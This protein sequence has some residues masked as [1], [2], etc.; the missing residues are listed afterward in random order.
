MNLPEPLTSLTQEEL[1]VLRPHIQHISFPEGT[2]I[3]R[4]GSVGDRCY[5]IDKGLVRV[6]LERTEL[7]SESVLTFLDEGAILGELSLL[8]QL[9]RSASA[10]AQTDVEARYIS[11]DSIDALTSTHPAVVVSIMSAL[12]R[13]AAQKLRQ[14]TGRLAT[15]IFKEKYPDIDALVEQAD[16]AYREFVSWPEDNVN[17]L[18][19]DLAQVVYDRAERLARETVETT[20]VGNIEDKVLKNR[21]ISHGIYQY[22]TGK[23]GHGPILED[24]HRKIT[25]L[26]SP[27][28]VVFGLIPMTN[29]V[30]TA[31]F[32]TLICLKGR[33]ALIMSF[34]RVTQNLGPMLTE[35]LRSVLRRHG[36]PMNLLQCIENRN[37]R[38]KTEM[39]MRHGKVSFILATGGVGMVRAAY[40]S[41]KPA[42]GVG[43]SNTPTLI[44][45]DADIRHAAHCVVVSKSFDNGL[46]C[47]SEH[48]LLVDTEIHDE[49]IEC[50]E[51]AGAAV[52]DK[53]EAERFDKIA[54][55]K[56]RFRP[57]VMGLSAA[58]LAKRAGITRK[59]T[60]KVI[61]VPTNDASI[62]NPWAHEKMAPI[63]SL[64]TVPN[65][66]KGF[67]LALKLLEIEG[68]GHTAIIH[69]R[70]QETAGNFGVS[71]PASRILVNSPGSQGVI[72]LTTGLTP[73][74]T[75][76]CGTFGGN[77]TTD[78]VN[79]HHLLNIKRLAEF[80]E[81]ESEL[82]SK[83]FASDGPA[84]RNIKTPPVESSNRK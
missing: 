4:E 11:T 78:N 42:I 40:S 63:T 29:P 16:A 71:M 61:V 7:D 26:A 12:G 41:G 25:E 84:P 13:G 62:D 22:L 14:T 45:R 68:T 3:F 54:V 10:F 36:A 57:E 9:P 59:N 24:K 46:I 65:N 44:C 49:F 74:L 20:K 33:N 55:S 79:Y 39:F 15:H 77:S 5:V 37:S 53:D 52:L 35:M 19:K 82:V 83:I 69:T 50:L 28:G 1:A 67:M 43:P 8:D 34:N 27:V 31:I 56:T 81:P 73:S 58:T 66:E 80:K 70:N 72:G 38:R 75:L 17:A 47:G 48:N 30:A 32:K 60:I 2:C 21:G 51:E 76:G 18:L 64:F 6:E 23:T